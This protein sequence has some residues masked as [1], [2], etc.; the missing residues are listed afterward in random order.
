MEHDLQIT[1]ENIERIV[2]Q[3]SD[4]LLRVAMHYT[5]NRSEAEDVV[6]TVFLKLVRERPAFRDTGHERAWLLRVAINQCKDLLKSVW[7]SRTAPLEQLPDTPAPEESGVLDAV[8]T[9][10]PNWRDT[11]YL[12]YYEG[13][14]VAEIAALLKTREGTVMSWLHRARA[15]LRTLLKG[16]FDNEL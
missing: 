6:Q 4:T 12:Y 10:P 7:H 13:L 1:Q 3:Y 8:R 14:R 5:Q 11:V 2:N 16:E 15:Q 9:L